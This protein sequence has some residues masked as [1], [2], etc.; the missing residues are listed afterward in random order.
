MRGDGVRVDGDPVLRASTELV[1]A[2]GAVTDAKR[3][4][5]DELADL[6]DGHHDEVRLRVVDEPSRGHRA[7]RAWISRRFGA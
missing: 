5:L 7:I 6:A 4:G 1:D 3:A 2:T